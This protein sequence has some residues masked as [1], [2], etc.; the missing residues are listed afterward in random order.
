MISNFEEMAANHQKFFDDILSWLGCDEIP[1]EWIENW[2][3]FLKSTGALH[4]VEGNNAAWK[5][6]FD[7]HE[8]REILAIFDDMQTDRSRH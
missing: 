8:K 3:S 7:P 4:F 6:F 2:A 1:S 5:E